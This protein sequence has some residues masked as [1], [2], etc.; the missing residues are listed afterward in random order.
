MITQIAEHFSYH[1]V[2]F[3]DTPVARKTKIDMAALI[4]QGMISISHDYYSILIY[5]RFI[6]ALP[7]PN[8]VSIADCAHW[9]SVSDDSDTEEDYDAGNMVAGEHMNEDE[10]HQDPFVP[11]PQ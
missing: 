10:Q 2:L 3:E 1:A 11:P 8:R 5:K 7:N 9:L 6:I 4:Q